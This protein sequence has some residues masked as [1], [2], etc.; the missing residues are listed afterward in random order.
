M[1]FY[2]S[3]SRTGFSLVEVLVVLGISVMIFGALF[4]SVQYTL[5]VISNSSAKL[6]ALS[7]ANDRME[8][9]RSL[10][11]DDVGTISGI[12]AGTIPQNSTTVLNGIEFN[13]RV[14]VEYVDD[15]ADGV[16]TSTTTD[17]NGIPS[18]YKRIKIEISW[19]MYEQSDQISLVSNIVPRSIETTAG[20]G[21]VRVN[22]LDA[23]STFLSGAEVRLVNNTVSPAV[24]VTRYSD[25]NGVALFSG[26]PAASDYQVFVTAPGYSTDQ[27]YEASVDNP[28]PI[29]SPFAVLES[30]ISTVTFQIGE[31]GD[32]L[33]QTLSDITEGT[34]IELFTDLS[35][36]AMSADVT[37]TG[38]A[39]LLSNTAGIY[40]SNGVLFLQPVAPSTLE[41]WEKVVV[42]GDAPIGTSYVTNIYTGT[43][44]SYTLISNSDLPGN[45]TGFTGNIIDL[46]VLDAVTYPE[47]TVGIA[48]TTGNS[49]ITPSIDEVSLYYRAAESSRGNVALSVFGTKIIGTELD[50]TPIYKVSLPIITNSSGESVASDIE[51]DTYSIT[52]T[53]GYALARTCEQLP[54][55]LAPGDVRT[56]EMVLVSPVTNSLRVTVTSD[57]G[58][59]IPGAEV[60][61]SRPSFSET[62]TTDS[63]GQVYFSSGV[64]ADGDY[65]ITVSRNGYVSESVNPVAVTGETNATVILTEL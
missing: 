41:R 53:D 27:T 43:T 8:Y 6:S 49:A 39:V 18:D 16:L 30:D 55:G 63:C 22:V 48:L 52:N 26:A 7:L 60:T 51:F 35:G 2:Q 4:G 20:G 25:T 11:Y 24:D 65:D 47:I 14:L 21:T 34:W 31:L 54:L 29:V 50:T 33:L 46:S 37:V 57:P 58:E 42:I 10:P 36:V 9:F 44:P 64:E 56:V 40:V 45:D 59:Y 28:N 15:P 19:T 61:L 32:I 23:D 12:P 38:N 62:L 3:Q 1:K 5:R 13:E 17:S